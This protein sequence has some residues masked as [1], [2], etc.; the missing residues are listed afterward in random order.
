MT[1]GRSRAVAVAVA[2]DAPGI[3][4][5]YRP[6][7]PFRLLQFRSSFV[8]KGERK[9]SF[10]CGIDA[11]LFD[12]VHLQKDGNAARGETARSLC[13]HPSSLSPIFPSFPPPLPPSLGESRPKSNG[14]G[15]PCSGHKTRMGYTPSVRPSVRP[16]ALLPSAQTKRPHSLHIVRTGVK[17]V[18]PP[19]LPGS[20]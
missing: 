5:V 11:F 3:I 9:H 2:G 12:S 8:T 16:S 4:L 6:F 17:L 10:I 18:G 1:D 19:F 13:H 20:I 14:G 15:N 7:L